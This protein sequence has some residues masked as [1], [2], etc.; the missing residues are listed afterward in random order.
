MTKSDPWLRIVAQMPRN[1]GILQV[2]D[3]TLFAGH[4]AFEAA[5]CSTVPV[6]LVGPMTP[7]LTRFSK[8]PVRA[9]YP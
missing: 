2:H 7:A 6:T 1:R 9:L 8:T 4:T 3:T 5:F